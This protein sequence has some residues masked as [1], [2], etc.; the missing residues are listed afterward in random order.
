MG[1]CLVSGMLLLALWSCTGCSL[2]GQP[3]AYMRLPKLPAEQETLKSTIESSLPP[4]AALIRPSN[5]VQAGA[6]S[7]VD[8][9]G[10]G[11]EEAV[12]YYKIKES[13]Q[14]HGE[15]W[16]ESDGPW[17]RIDSFEGAGYELDEL[18]FERITLEDASRGVN[19]VAAY[20]TKE[21][22][23]K[24]LAVYAL[25]NGK[26][27]KKFE[28]PYTDYVIDDLTGD[29]RQDLTVILHDREKRTSAAVLYQYEG[30]KLQKLSTLH[31]DGTVS[32]YY[33]MIS[34]R[35]TPELRGVVLDAAVGAHSSYTE[36]LIYRDG[37]LRRA[38]DPERTYKA[39]S[40]P[41]EDADRDGI[42]D[43]VGM[44][45]PPGWEDQP[46]AVIPWIYTYDR[47]DGSGGFERVLQRYWNG[48]DG[49][50]FDFPPEWPKE[51]TLEI[52]EGSSVRFITAPDSTERLAEIR[53][54]RAD[55]WNEE[56]TDWLPVHRTANTVLALNR[57]AEAYRSRLHLLS[58]MKSEGS[59]PSWAES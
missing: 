54:F 31:L 6:I 28:L 19:L 40:A 12:F 3:G 57:E 29:E 39:Y 22:A 58:E 52:E 17:K 41:S 50:Y 13:E 43:V 51:T 4:G 24:G 14:L 5:A 25:E 11:S 59:A 53:I 8:L 35:V 38:F 1:R 45:E 2:I 46:V 49:Y 23:P 20:A 15:I 18:R 33:N 44:V 16:S 37:R 26:A 34:G 30:N 27:V 21:D 42:L 47:W 10:D 55:D 36:M 9:D 32:G 56:Q 7:L 48:Q